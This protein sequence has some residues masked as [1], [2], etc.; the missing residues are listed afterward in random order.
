MIF[1]AGGTLASWLIAVQYFLLSVSGL[2]ML[3]SPFGLKAWSVSLLIVLTSIAFRNL[4]VRMRHKRN[5]VSL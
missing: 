4:A 2:Y 1:R 5:L 3:L